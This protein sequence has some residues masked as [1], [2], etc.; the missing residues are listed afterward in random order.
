LEFTTNW[1]DSYFTTKSLYYD[2]PPKIVD[3]FVDFVF[4]RNLG[5]IFVFIVIFACFWAI[6]ML[7]GNK[8]LI[9]HKIWQPFFA[10]I[11]DKRYG[12]M[13]INDVLSL[14]YLPILFFSFMQLNNLNGGGIYSFNAFVTV[15]FLIAAI[16]MPVIW[17]LLWIK[18]TPE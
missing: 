9:P 1:F 15:I 5:Q 14:F 16:L 17:L 2:I 11:S 8:R 13:V 4:L 7:L 10:S 6:F 18:R 12:L 3:I